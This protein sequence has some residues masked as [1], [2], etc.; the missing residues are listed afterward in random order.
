MG[1]VPFL[2]AVPHSVTLNFMISLSDLGTGHPGT[3]SSAFSSRELKT[4]RASLFRRLI[5]HV[6]RACA[7]MGCVCGRCGVPALVAFS[8]K[9]LLLSAA[10]CSALH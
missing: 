9:H 5:D 1:D 6:R 10:L 2:P 7:G 4:W 3:K 8:G